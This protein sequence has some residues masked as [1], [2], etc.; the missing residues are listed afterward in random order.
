MLHV[1]ANCTD[2]VRCICIAFAGASYS[3]GIHGVPEVTLIA[4][5]PVQNQ[6]VCMLTEGCVLQVAPFDLLDTLEQLDVDVRQRQQGLLQLPI[7]KE[8]STGAH[9]ILSM[10]GKQ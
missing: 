5:Q 6:Q 10:A 8:G 4:S 9:Q 2:H 3:A 7:E 1:T